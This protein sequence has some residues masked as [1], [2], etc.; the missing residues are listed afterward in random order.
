MAVILALIA[1]AIA[2]LIGLAVSSTRDSTIATSDQIVRLSQGRLAARTSVDVASFVIRNHTNVLDSSGVDV[3][4]LLFDAEQIGASTISARVQDAV[5][6]RSPTRSTV[7]ARYS[8]SAVEAGGAPP[9]TPLPAPPV[10]HTITA[11]E[12]APWP[13]VV[14]RADLD[15][16]EFAL[17]ASEAPALP[18]SQPKVTIGAGAEVSVWRDSPAAALGE[19]IVIGS[20]RRR[21]SDIAVNPSARLNGVQTLTEGAFATSDEDAAQQ[22]AD[23]VRAIPSDISVPR[24]ALPGPIGIHTSAYW[25]ALDAPYSDL[26]N[27]PYGPHTRLQLPPSGRFSSLELSFEG[28][29]QPGQWRVVYLRGL[30]VRIEGCAWKFEVPTMLIVEGKL[31]LTDGTRLEVGEHGALT[32][33]ALDGLLLDG[34]YVGPALGAGE[35]WSTTGA[36][37]YAG[38]GASRVTILEGGNPS[39]QRA[40]YSTDPQ[41]LNA[42][43][44]RAD[45]AGGSS[46]EIVKEG[47]RIESNSVVVGEVY[48]P[49]SSV[50]VGPNCALYGRALAHRI[51]VLPNGRVFYDP[52]LNTGSGWLNPQSGIWASGGGV[53]PEVREIPVLSDEYL[54]RFTTATGIAVE[55]A[56]NG[57]LM[58][59]DANDAGFVKANVD[60]TESAPEWC[61]NSSEGSP[62]PIPGVPTP[63]GVPSADYVFPPMQ[64]IYGVTR[65]FRGRSEL[66]GH[67][68]FGMPAT[69]SR[70]SVAISQ[71]LDGNGKPQIVDGPGGSALQRAIGSST[72]FSQWFRDVPTTNLSLPMTLR[73]TRAES[74]GHTPANPKWVYNAVGYNPLVLE[75]LGYN[76]LWFPPSAPGWNLGLTAELECSFEYRQDK[77]QWLYVSSTEDL[78]VYLDGKK[79]V[80]IGGLAQPTTRSIDL[81]TV[82]PSLGLVDRRQYTIKF[83]L[84]NRYLQQRSQLYLWLNFPIESG[85]P[86]SVLRYPHL[87][88]LKAASVSISQ[89][90]RAEMYAPAAD[91][92]MLRPPRILGF[93]TDLVGATTSAP[94]DPQ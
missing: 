78:W 80:D 17:L 66:G 55:P 5:T 9:G 58:T 11:V 42:V 13:D 43:A 14:A 49:D 68:D 45:V 30:D 67:V 20:S 70:R 8:A 39:L 40:I 63:V 56:G 82:A 83:F 46:P 64:H 60:A 3:D 2:I 28:A 76:D 35:A 37:T 21:T 57:I 51:D 16:S 6:G 15:L 25:Q 62:G 69:E 4:R 1:V 32:I 41:I 91:P 61:N 94:A 81:N 71:G 93:T 7:A 85:P 90:L 74:Y 88:A 26:N 54:A 24:L 33:V 48:A 59:A 19:P 52:Q 23:G 75:G 86:P 29:L 22:L 12:R 65:D 38:V 87:E 79:I 50:T 53:R 73:L 72:S 27:L 36:Q 89:N 77:A 34:S 47:T 44:R 10:V 31:R 92:A 84:A 18:G